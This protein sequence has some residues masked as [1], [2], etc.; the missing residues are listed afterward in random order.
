PGHAA[1]AGSAEFARRHPVDD[2]GA[3]RVVKDLTGSGVGVDRGGVHRLPAVGAGPAGAGV[4]EL[5]CVVQTLAVDS[6]VVGVLDVSNVSD[7][8]VRVGGMQS[9]AV[10]VGDVQPAG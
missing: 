1:V 4:G 3:K 9:E 8:L 2:V 6:V 5:H 10:K 7:R